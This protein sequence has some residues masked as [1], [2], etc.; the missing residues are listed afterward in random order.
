MRRLRV[1]TWHVHGSYLYYLT[2]APHDF[3][4]PV[5][6]GRPEGYGGRSGGFAWGANVHEVAADVLA[7]QQFDVVLFQSRRNYECDQ[8]EVL[9]PA[10][11]RLPRVYLEHDPPRESPTDTRHPVDDPDVLLVH[12]TPFN[13]LMWDAGRTPARVVEHGVRVPDDIR[14]TGELTRGIVVVNDLARRGRRLGRDVF[15]RVRA[16]VPLDLAGMDSTALGGLGDLPL[17][18]LHARL[19]RYRFFFNPI[20]YT[21]LGLAVCEA[22]MIGLPIL[23][24]ATTEMSTAVQSGVNG[25]VETDLGRL[26]GHMRRLL[27][28]PAEAAELAVGARR[29]ARRRF[30]IDRFAADWSRVLGEVTGCPEGQVTEPA[31]RTA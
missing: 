10:Q 4:L 16:D 23:G 3:Y 1:L 22:M 31:R 5:K 17:R 9:S 18:E 29:L 27:A 7:Q 12:V 21:S 11:R 2:H 8:F 15:D 14:W 30:G 24:L 26:V 20:R 13:A 25:Y 6:P 19:G 28:D